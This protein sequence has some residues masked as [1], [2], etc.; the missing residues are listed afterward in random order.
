MMAG[1]NGR[2]LRSLGR[3]AEPFMLGDTAFA[4]LRDLI[5]ERTGML[6]DDAKRAAL[7]DKLS[8]LVGSNGI[9]SFLDYYYLL[10]YDGKA[11]QHWT[12]LM[13][14]LSVPETYFWRQAE[15]IRVVAT[16]IAPTHFAAH[17][18]RPL[19]VWSAACCTGEEPISIAMALDQV[20]LLGR[21]PIEI[22]ATDGS[23]TM[24]ERAKQAVYAE[25]SFRQLPSA[26]RERYFE[27]C[28]ADRWRASRSL[29]RHIRWGVANLA[30]RSEIERFAGADVILCRNVFIYFADD[31][32]KKVV[33]VFSER[34]PPDGCLFLGAAESLMRLGV[35]LELVE[36]GPA[37][38]YVKDGRSSA[39][40]RWR[41]AAS[42]T[43]SSSVAQSTTGLDRHV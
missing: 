21:Y 17:P 23:A 39:V 34:M 31:A 41:S 26:L 18:D 13:N 24:I 30:S 12:A 7:A 20:G 5:V 37:F 25:R 28:G 36:I 32:I 10:R 1:D 2:G 43:V 15:Q 29:T 11:E 35:D 6:F 40:E 27:P 16:I 14:R 3:G 8:E 33:R 42:G 22:D 9:S 4:L 19:R 38:G